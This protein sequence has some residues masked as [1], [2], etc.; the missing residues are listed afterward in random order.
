MRSAQR[1]LRLCEVNGG[2]FIKVG[3]HLGALDYLIPSEYVST[4][5][6]LHSS[7]PQSSFEEILGV[8]KEDLKEEVCKYYSIDVDN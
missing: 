5:K 1:L 8:L 4:M 7:A 2:A 3:Q 6:V